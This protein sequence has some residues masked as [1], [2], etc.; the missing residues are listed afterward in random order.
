[1]DDRVSCGEGG[2]RSGQLHHSTPPGGHLRGA[3]DISTEVALPVGVDFCIS[4]RVTVIDQPMKML[5]AELVVPGP[6][7]VFLQ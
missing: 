1:M 5:V 7:S 4:G 6:M 3:P 2:F